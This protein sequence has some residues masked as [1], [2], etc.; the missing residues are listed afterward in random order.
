MTE[1]RCGSHH[2]QMRQHS[3]IGAVLRYE[4]QQTLICVTYGHTE[5]RSGHHHYRVLAVYALQDN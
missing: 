2:G 1:A 5:M 4:I 3:L